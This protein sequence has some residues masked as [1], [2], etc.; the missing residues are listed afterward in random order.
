MMIRINNVS[1][2]QRVSFLLNIDGYV[3]VSG[4]AVNS[5]GNVVDCAIDG[6]CP[7]KARSIQFNL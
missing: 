4:S 7:K 3:I 6:I 2:S 1:F 5:T